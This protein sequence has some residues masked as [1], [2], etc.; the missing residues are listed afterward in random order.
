MLAEIE[1]IGRV[2]FLEFKENENGRFIKLS[3]GC[4]KPK[5]IGDEWEENTT[6]FKVIMSG[7]K[8]VEYLSDLSKGDLVRVVGEI[9]IKE[10]C[11]QD[12]TPYKDVCVFAE[13][14]KRLSKSF[15]AESNE[16]NEGNINDDI[17]F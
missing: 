4:S 16:G 9:R 13:K 7:D 3:V 11:K 15:K 8:R 12:G 5:K 10:T 14:V 6:W 2:G 1:L 17:P